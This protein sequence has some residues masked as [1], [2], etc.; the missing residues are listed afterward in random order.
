MLSFLKG[1]F[2]F[3]KARAAARL[4]NSR[5]CR[6]TRTAGPSADHAPEPGPGFVTVRLAWSCPERQVDK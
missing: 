6:W 2:R 3:C 1:V 5:G 4:R